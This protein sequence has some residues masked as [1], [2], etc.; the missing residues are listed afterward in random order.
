MLHILALIL[1]N[2]SRVCGSGNPESRPGQSENQNYINRAYRISQLKNQGV[3]TYPHKFFMTH[4]PNDVLKMTEDDLLDK[5][6]VSLAG[7]VMAVRNQ[8]SL[9][10]IDLL[11]NGQTVQVVWTTPKEAQND[12]SVNLRRG[13]IIGVSGHP[14][15][16]K[17]G[18]RSVFTNDLKVL[19]PSVRTFPADYYGLK[20]TETIY[21]Q[22]YLDLIMNPESRQRF[23]TKTKIYAYLRMFLDSRG[24]IEVE[25]PMMNQIAGGAAANPFI[26]HHND[27]KMN[28]YM[29]ISPELYLKQLIVGGMERV[30]EIGRQM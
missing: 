23:I 26:T 28:L 17:S 9:V 21:R 30:Y 25:T 5:N 3:N 24:F 20:N 8:G 27:L 19:S 7:R 13:D 18:Q 29:R 10:F 14:G 15:D 11:Y 22:R 4:T 16:T 1:S 12:M 6:H 2:L